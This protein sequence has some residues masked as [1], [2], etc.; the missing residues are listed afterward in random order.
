M[1]YKRRGH[2]TRLAVLRISPDVLDM[3]GVVIADG[4]AASNGTR[5]EPSPDGLAVLDA[6]HVYAESWTDP[7]LL[8]QAE[9]KRR[10]CAEVLI[11][12]VVPPIFVTGC[13]VCHS[14]VLGSFHEVA[15]NLEVVVRKHVFF[16]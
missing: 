7:N 6:Q 10:R 1:M 8:V 14:S 13:Y 15:P 12:D 5:F 11:P 4:N 9:R 16:G 3:A 2:R